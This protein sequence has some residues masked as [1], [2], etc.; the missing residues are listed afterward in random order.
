MADSNQPSWL[1]PEV[2]SGGG[3][4]V[5][6]PTLNASGNNNGGAAS[7]SAAA[8]DSTAPAAQDASA[9]AESDAQLP[10]VIL[11]MRLANMGVAVALIIAS[12]RS[13]SLF[14]DCAL[15]WVFFE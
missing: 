13:V 4:G 12:V 11:V 6:P 10:S 5:D 9:S 7:S 2:I 14:L 1:S 3:G 8:A 15:F